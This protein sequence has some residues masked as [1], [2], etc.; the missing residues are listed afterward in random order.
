M[1]PSDPQ[2]QLEYPYI[3]RSAQPAETRQPAVLPFPSG[4]T[5]LALSGVAMV[6]V[7]A[8]FAV[9]PLIELFDDA[10]VVFWCVGIMLAEGFILAAWLVWGGGLFLQRLAL[11]WLAAFLLG[12]A[13]L[14]G[15]VVTEGVRDGDIRA[16]LEVV[17][18][19]LPLVSLAIQLPL[20][21]ARLYFGWQIVDACAES[22]PARP[23]AIRDL[24]FGMVVVAVSLALARLAE[25]MNRSSDGWL[26]WA[27]L[28]PSLAGIS[29]V[30][31]LPVA[32]WLLCLRNVAVGLI[33]I[34]IHTTI[35]IVVTVVIMSM[36]ERIN[37][38]E[39]F[40]IATVVASFAA[41]L[42]AA[43]LAARAAGF[44]L[45]VGRNAGTP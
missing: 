31:V 27:I 28:I 6:F 19:S 4:P 25:G 33:A 11:H 43:A 7:L 17:P 32:V 44:R 40:A 2:P 38:R 29:L 20:W 18:F 30:S 45:E 14:A 24:M 26:V 5:W 15:A 37:L 10:F 34:P 12:L 13:W 23:L 36:T 8:N 41:T 9:V 39:V 22:A 16:V 21:I 35:A 42:A 3:A 1:S